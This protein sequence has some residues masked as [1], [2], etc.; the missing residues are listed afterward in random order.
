VSRCQDTGGAGPGVTWAANQPV[1][2][3]L[4]GSVTASNEAEMVSVG[5]TGPANRAVH[6]TVQR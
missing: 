4:Y 3:L 1:T 5:T 6:Q 2:A